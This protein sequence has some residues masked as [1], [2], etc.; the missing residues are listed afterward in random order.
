M[1]P[2]LVSSLYALGASFFFAVCNHLLREGIR[3]SSPH[4]AIWLVPLAMLTVLGLWTSLSPPEGPINLRGLAWLIPGGILSPGLA[5]PF[6]VLSLGHLGVARSASIAH[7]HPF[8]ATAFAVLF[9]GERPGVSVILGMV[10][11]AGGVVLITSRGPSGS[12]ERRHLFFPIGS[13]LLLAS[14]TAIRKA[15]MIYM[16]YPVFGAFITTVGSLPSFFLMVPHLHGRSR[17]GLTRQG[18]ACFA[19]AGI[20]NSLAYF[21]VFEALRLGDV[22]V[23]APLIA[24]SPLFSLILAHLFLRSLERLSW[25]VAGGTFLTVLGTMTLLAFQGR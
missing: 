22:S 24:T 21:C 10:V 19:A 13:G 2:F 20:F 3:D 7:C 17:K 23:V 14:S 8:A 18:A 25:Q 12:F 4:R 6:F 16:P 11:I 1:S 5:L 9:I 15:G